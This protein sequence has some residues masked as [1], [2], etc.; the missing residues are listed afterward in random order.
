MSDVSQEQFDNNTSGVSAEENANV[1]R[2]LDLRDLFEQSSKFKD[3]K[4]L[5]RTDSI[6]VTASPVLKKVI[7]DQTKMS[8][9]ELI[10]NCIS[11]YI[12]VLKMMSFPHK[13]ELLTLKDDITH[14]SVI[15]LDLLN[16]KLV[17]GQGLELEA[18]IDQIE[19]V[20]N[21]DQIISD[22]MAE[23]YRLKAQIEWLEK[24][25]KALTRA[26]LG[27]IILVM[28]R[29]GTIVEFDKGERLRKPF[30]HDSTDNFLG[31]KFQDLFPRIAD[32]LKA[33][34]NEAFEGKK[35]ST[36]VAI[37]HNDR[38]LF[39]RQLSF[40]P[41]E[42]TEFLICI[43]TDRTDVTR[44]EQGTFELLNQVAKTVEMMNS[45]FYIIS[46]SGD[47]KDLHL[48]RFADTMDLNENLDIGENLFD[49]YPDF[50]KSNEFQDLLKKV[51]ETSMLQEMDYE[52]KDHDG[53]MLRTYR[54][55]VTNWT[56]GQ[57][58]ISFVNTTDTVL[59]VQRK[60]EVEKATAK[61]IDM[62]QA[63]ER[64]AHD[65]RTPLSVLIAGITTIPYLLNKSIRIID[66][67]LVLDRS[68]VIDMIE[69]KADMAQK[70][71]EDTL[72]MLDSI[73]KVAKNMDEV[74]KEEIEIFNLREK[75]E[76]IIS[77]VASSLKI[78]ERNITINCSYK[79]LNDLTLAGKT[80]INHVVQNLLS[81]AVKYSPDNSEVNIEIDED[82]NDLIITVS[83]NGIGM[84]EKDL[85][86][87][88]QHFFRTERSKSVSTGTGLGLPL[89]KACVDKH[90][91]KIE[92]TSIPNQ[93]TTFIVRLPLNEKA[94]IEI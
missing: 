11:G 8:L 56:E 5:L 80:T 70:A 51:K 87:L 49:L 30:D 37:S 7:E 72:E 78:D 66:S 90:K 91:G 52:V 24:R 9:E 50:Y 83:D 69:K 20:L 67:K 44:L 92:V 13:I 81:N 38:G 63:L 57:I 39:S 41:V 71:V 61:L 32:E 82:G 14:R 46:E 54:V 35:R 58:A 34:M 1:Y 36:Y 22:L 62:M 88:F 85:S 31:V 60:I 79:R 74:S 43:S 33:A 53:K 16:I 18:I 77:N 2:H 64:F 84:E 76:T 65:I 4:I 3:I 48:G 19:K 12:S 6:I 29:D 28:K 40:Y 73:L 26:M 47:I 27:G 45:A 94:T 25:D 55:S 10:Y 42:G 15:E 23:N 89:V 68:E 17:D 86:H 75:V 21:Q 59:A 93:G